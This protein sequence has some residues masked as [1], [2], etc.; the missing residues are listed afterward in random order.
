MRNAVVIFF[1][2]MNLIEYT[3]MNME[4]KKK[5]RI[6]K[7][8]RINDSKRLVNY[9]RIYTKLNE[10]KRKK[11]WM[12]YATKSQYIFQQSITGFTFQLYSFSFFIF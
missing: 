2:L 7:D 10:A 11:N 12:D 4:F 5:N 9:V 6:F 1:D 8:R 3:F